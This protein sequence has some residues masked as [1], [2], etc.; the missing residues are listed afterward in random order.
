VLTLPRIISVVKIKIARNAG[1]DES[2][3]KVLLQCGNFFA[4]A[5]ETHGKYPS[6]CHFFV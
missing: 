3:G 1:F 5:K 6:G 2:F 4:K